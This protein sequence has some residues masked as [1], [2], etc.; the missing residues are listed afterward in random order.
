MTFFLNIKFLSTLII[1]LS[2]KG[3][4]KNGAFLIGKLNLCAGKV[5]VL[6]VFKLSVFWVNG[7]CA[8]IL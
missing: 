3:F 8:S 2:I 7:F 5:I 4:S 1:P 6:S